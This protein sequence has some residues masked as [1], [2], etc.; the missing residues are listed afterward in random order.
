[1]VIDNMFVAEFINGKSELIH[2]S[3]AIMESD[4]NSINKS[5]ILQGTF[6]T[7][8]YVWIKYHNRILAAGSLNPTKI[9]KSEELRTSWT[10]IHKCL[11]CLM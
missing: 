3:D 5:K 7:F 1:M 11:S 9:K 10:W 6:D 2:I 8:S 4:T